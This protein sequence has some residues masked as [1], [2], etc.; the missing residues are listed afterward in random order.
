MLA[1]LGGSC[2]ISV[3]QHASQLC[4]A[5]CNGQGFCDDAT[6]ICH[7]GCAGAPESHGF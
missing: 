6:C 2:G 4:P 7:P 3:D 1:L 5:N